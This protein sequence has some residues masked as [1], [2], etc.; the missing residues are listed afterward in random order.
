VQTRQADV[1]DAA[2]TKPEATAVRVRSLL[3]SA[4]NWIWRVREPVLSVG[5]QKRK[6]ED[7][8]TDSLSL[9][10]LDDPSEDELVPLASKKRDAKNADLVSEYAF[11]SA[12]VR[13]ERIYGLGFVMLDVAGKPNELTADVCD[14][15]KTEDYASEL[16]VGFIHRL[17]Y[18]SIPR[19]RVT[20]GPMVVQATEAARRAAG[21]AAY[22]PKLVVSPSRREIMRAALAA[23]RG[24]VVPEP[25]DR[26]Y[27]G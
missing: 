23:A 26:P 3:V 21:V 12:I 14:V 5:T 9:F 11:A 4:P 17:L 27:G 25:A 7:G 6:Q 24:K 22:P 8:M 19:R 16:A 10:D 13:G 18:R 20:S 2:E 1:Q 15:S